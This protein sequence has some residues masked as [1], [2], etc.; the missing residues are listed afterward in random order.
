MV[1]RVV[2][3]DLDI[4]DSVLIGE[5][6][7]LPIVAALRNVMRHAWDHDARSARHGG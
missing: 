3:K 5:E 1:A 6:N 2:A 4:A 7:V